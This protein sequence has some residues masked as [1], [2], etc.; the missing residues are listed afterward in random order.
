MLRNSSNDY[1]DDL[2]VSEVSPDWQWWKITYTNGDASPV[3]CNKVREIEVLK[4]VKGG[5]HEVLVV[6]ASEKAVLYQE[7]ELSSQLEVRNRPNI[8]LSIDD[9]RN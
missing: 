5:G 6:Y 2:L 1:S 4:A 7:K 8:S 9:T 3:F